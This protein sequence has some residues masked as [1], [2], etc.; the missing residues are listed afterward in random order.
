MLPQRNVNYL[1]GALHSAAASAYIV[2]MAWDRLGRRDNHDDHFASPV[3]LPCITACTLVF[4]HSPTPL[5]VF[6]RRR[7]L[8]AVQMVIM[9]T[10]S[11]TDQWTT[12]RIGCHGPAVKNITR[13]RYYPIHANIA[14]YPI[15]QYRYRSNPTCGAPCTGGFCSP[16]PLVQRPTDTGT[17]IHILQTTATS[18][19]LVTYLIISN[20][21][22]S[23]WKLV[24]LLKSKYECAID[25]KLH[26]HWWHAVVTAHSWALTHG[27]HFFCMGWC[28]SCRLEF[29][30]LNQKFKCVNQ[31]I[32]TCRTNLPDFILVRFEMREPYYFFEH[33]HTSNKNSNKMRSVMRSGPDLKM[34]GS[35]ILYC[36]IA[37]WWH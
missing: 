37:S 21:S 33:C 30:M 13:Y 16:S 31:C 35:Q 27:W 12:N 36:L 3:Y 11:L 8:R 32:F 28:R 6:C 4:T 34:H 19:S 14:Q 15:T 25:R 9:W 23:W 18:V 1:A 20:D 7:P 10:A 17:C 22:W 24:F 29:V 2:C 5:A 26:I